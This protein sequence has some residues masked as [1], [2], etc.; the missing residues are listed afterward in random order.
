MS[1]A[2]LQAAIEGRLKLFQSTNVAWPNTR[3]V[4]DP[5]TPWLQPTI[6]W[7]RSTAL[8]PGES[9]VVR[10]SGMFLVACY[11]PTPGGSGAALAKAD[12]VLDWFPRGL[13]LGTSDGLQVRFE[14]GSINQ[15]RIEDEW[16]QVP[17]SCPWFCLEDG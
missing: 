15:P 5:R 14:T 9:S 13:S 16:Y 10:H 11:F 7:G 1:L 2:S 4:P 6:V 8:G 17:V 12:Q 3:F